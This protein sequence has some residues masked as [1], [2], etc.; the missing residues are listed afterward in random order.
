MRLGVLGGTLDPIHYAHLFLAE[1]ARVEL[2]LEHVLFVPNGTPPHRTPDEVS[3]PRRRLAMTE[4]A[5]RGNPAFRA[6]A[7]EVER[8]GPSYTVDTLLGLRREFPGAEL[9][10]LTGIDAVAE[11]RTW[12]RWERVTDL[13]TLVAATRPGYTVEMLRERLPPACLERIRVLPTLYL[14]ISA[15]QIRERVRQGLPI[16]YL[17][18]DPVAAYIDEQ[19]LYRG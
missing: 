3:A 14:A 11:L 4:L 19:G 7:A 9:F 6:S 17:T 1:D 15:T 13:C 10:F 8:P 16:R 18:P 5:V 12:S 2:G